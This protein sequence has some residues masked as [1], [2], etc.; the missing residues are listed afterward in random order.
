[1]QRRKVHQTY[2]S[3]HSSRS[4]CIV[5][6]RIK[7]TR[8]KEVGSSLISHQA[9]STESTARRRVLDPVAPKGHSRTIPSLSLDSSRDLESPSVF[10]HSREFSTSEVDLSTTHS[11]LPSSSSFVTTSTTLTFVDLAGSERMGKTGKE[12]RYK[13]TQFINSSLSALGDVV[14]A[15]SRKDRERREGESKELA[16]GNTHSR[17]SSSSRSSSHLSSSTVKHIPYRNSKLTRLL[18]PALSGNCKTILIAN[19]SP[20]L[21]DCSESHNTM[22]FATRARY[23]K[24]MNMDNIVEK[25]RTLL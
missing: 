1:M 2:M 20:L 8:R 7:R 6:I 14:C 11:K 12:A 10:H 4:H 23:V 16:V 15:L 24:S 9:N 19:I 18:Q 13:E 21:S 17:S 25:A 22:R 5:T 3:H